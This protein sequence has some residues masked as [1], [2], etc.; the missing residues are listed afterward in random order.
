MILSAWTE[1][2]VLSVGLR[3]GRQRLFVGLGLV[4]PFLILA[5]FLQ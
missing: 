1:G 2:P 3:V 4:G 5:A